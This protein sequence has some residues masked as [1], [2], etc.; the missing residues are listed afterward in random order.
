MCPWRSGAQER[1]FIEDSWTKVQGATY[2]ELF[3]A[4]E[5]LLHRVGGENLSLH[6]SLLSKETNH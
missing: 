2:D 3:E 4:S 1:T 5:G 6:G